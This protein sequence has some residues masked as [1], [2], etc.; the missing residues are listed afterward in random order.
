MTAEDR[1]IALQIA[2]MSQCTD[3]DVYGRFVEQL[4]GDLMTDDNAEQTREDE[5]DRTA[6]ERLRGRIGRR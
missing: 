6:F 2:T 3:K 5:F 4:S 1:L